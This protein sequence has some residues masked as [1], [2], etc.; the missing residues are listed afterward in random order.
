MHQRPKG[1]HEEAEAEEAEDLI[2]VASNQEY[3]TRFL[4]LSVFDTERC[5]KVML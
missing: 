2:E 5:M 1:F 4:L 3:D